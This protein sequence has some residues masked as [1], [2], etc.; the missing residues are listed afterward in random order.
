MKLLGLLLIHSSPKTLG[1]QVKVPPYK[2]KT[3][4]SKKLRKSCDSI[5]FQLT[6]VD[7]ATD[8]NATNRD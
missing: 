5:C 3:R 2:V 8:R 1:S 4:K 7:T 6:F